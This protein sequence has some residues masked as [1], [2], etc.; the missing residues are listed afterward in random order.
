MDELITFSELLNASIAAE[1]A[2]QKTYL[3]F[4]SMF[5]S[6]PDIAAFWQAMA[7]DEEQHARI[8]A[9][10]HGRVS[11]EDLTVN[12]DIEMAEQA[13]KLQTLEVL[14]LTESVGNLDDAYRVAF[15]LESS[16]INTVFN[17]LAIRFLSADESHRIVSE[18]IDRHLLRLAEFSRRFGTAEQCKLIAAIR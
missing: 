10:I 17:F 13:Y 2:A 11:I 12:V 16:E 18:V 15:E 7:D 9:G 1:D 4:K 6:H 5:L 8:L 14:G 3:A